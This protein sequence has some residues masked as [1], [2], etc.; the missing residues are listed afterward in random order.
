MSAIFLYRTLVIGALASAVTMGLAVADDYRVYRSDDRYDERYDQYRDGYGGG[1]DAARRV[2]YRLD[3]RK[4]ERL[5]GQCEQF[6]SLKRGETLSDI[7]EYC[8]VPVAAILDANPRLY[9]PRQIRAGDVIRLPDVRGEVYEGRRRFSYRGRYYNDDYLPAGV[10]ETDNRGRL[11]YTVRPGDTLAQISHVYDVSLRDIAGLNPDL[12]PRRLEIGERVYLPG[13][14]EYAPRVRETER[15]HSKWEGR[16][17]PLVSIYPDRGPRDGEILIVGDGFK[18]GGEVALYLGRERGEMTRIRVV[19]ADGDGRIR[20]TLRLPEDYRYDEAYWAAR[21]ADGDYVL[22][23]AYKVDRG[24]HDRYDAYKEHYGREYRQ[25]GYDYRH[26]NPSLAVVEKNRPGAVALIATGFPPESRVAIYAGPHRDDLTLIARDKSDF[27]GEARVDTV[28]PAHIA[29]GRTVFVARA[30]DRIAGRAQAVEVEHI[31]GDDYPYDLR[32]AALAEEGST[33][34][35]GRFKRRASEMLASH[36]FVEPPCIVSAVDLRDARPSSRETALVGVIA[37][38]D[39]RCAWLRDDA[40][41]Y[42]ALYGGLS[43]FGD[44]DRVVVRGVFGAGGRACSAEALRV[45]SIDWAPR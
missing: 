16:L 14:A 9:G 35:Y 21:P 38:R 40:G 42:R 2:H 23:E 18:Q 24:R 3:E 12:R 39:G 33:S 13:Y 4:A 37:D 7:A 28:L 25:S 27:R 36:D 15:R 34:F 26:K 29:D 20:E 22:S 19:E 30:D 31:R 8:D 44:G 6:V 1:V 45:T 5:D 10:L 11:F 32:D 43:G 17:D 41:S